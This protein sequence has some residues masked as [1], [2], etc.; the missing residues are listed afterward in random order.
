MNNGRN[1][2]NPRFVYGR[3]YV[4]PAIELLIAEAPLIGAAEG[5]H[6][7]DRIIRYKPTGARTA[8]GFYEY[9]LVEESSLA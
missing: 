1:P 5:L 8:S 7:L 2:G 3:R 4:E 9:E 6:I